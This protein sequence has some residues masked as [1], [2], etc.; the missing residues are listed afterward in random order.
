MNS[1]AHIYNTEQSQNAGGSRRCKYSGGSG[2]DRLKVIKNAGLVTGVPPSLRD[3]MASLIFASL[4]N[5]TWKKYGSAWAALD[6]YQTYIMKELQWPLSKET[7]RGYVVYLITV[8]RLKMTSAR[9]YLSSLACLHRLKGFPNH[10]MDD[11]VVRT[12]MRGAE[13]LQMITPSNRENRRRVMTVPMLR[14][15][16]HR[17]AGSG[18]EKSA[19][20]TI[21]SASLTAFFG[22]ARMGELLSPAESW[23]DTTSTLTWACVQY[24]KETDSF[25]LHIRLAKMRSP[26][27]EFIDL[28]PFKKIK[29]LCPVAAL[30]KQ[31]RYQKTLGKGGH[32]DP[33]FTYPSGNFVTKEAFNKALRI[34]LKD[35]VDFEEDTIS[36]H[37]FRA[38]LPSLISQYPEL[39]SLED[40]KNWG[41]W[42][43]EAYAKYTRLGDV[44]K[45]KLFGMIADVIN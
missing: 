40:I 10:Q 26:Q 14:H 42:S 44:Q 34:L 35:V 16:G 31:W 25:M 23:F 21:W 11:D 37:S 1:K 13:N 15:L 45:K 24:R 38:G 41:R 30:K 2:Q 3:G 43:G 7:L 33:V 20:Q 5:S 18:W 32:E 36:C 12:I 6:D 39:M 29:G 22:T 19:I 17:L 9:A 27:G 28:F 8:R 4:A